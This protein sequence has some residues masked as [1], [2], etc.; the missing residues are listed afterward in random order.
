MQILYN[1]KNN[2]ADLFLTFQLDKLY[3]MQGM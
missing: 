1:Y 2:A 3:D